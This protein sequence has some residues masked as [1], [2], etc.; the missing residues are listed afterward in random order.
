MD[1]TQVQTALIESLCNQQI[2]LVE[3]VALGGFGKSLLAVWAM[4]TEAVRSQFSQVLWINFQN[5]PSFNTFGRWIHQELGLAIDDPTITDEALIKQAIYRLSQKRCLVVM[6]QLEML[7]GSAN[8]TAFKAFVSQWLQQGRRSALLTT[9]RHHFELGASSEIS[10]RSINLDLL[11]FQDSEGA[12]FLDK[13]G[14]TTQLP[15]GLQQLSH[16]S[17]GH[18]LFLKLAASWVKETSTGRLD[19]PGLQFF[20]RLFRQKL[21]SL[22]SQVGEIFNRLLE[23]LMS[24]QRLALLEVSVYRTAFDLSKVQAMQPD[25]VEADVQQ[26]EDKGFL[27]RQNDR[28]SMHPLVR[29]F[30]LEVSQKENYESEAH[31]KAITFFEVMIADKAS[32]IENHLE[33]FYHLYTVGDYS[34][35]YGVIQSCK[36]WLMLRGHYR[37]LVDIYKQLADV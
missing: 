7:D 3:V 23:Q 15:E 30:V 32:V 22:E 21:G 25:I 37:L 35:A 2:R 27:L 9:T 1:R 12:L 29:Q 33:C 14:V 19:T 31:R 24:L 36:N 28:W 18:P 11:G 6:D 34:A 10:D 26:L 20:E 13:Q 5:V 4:E 8:K 16:F 17:K